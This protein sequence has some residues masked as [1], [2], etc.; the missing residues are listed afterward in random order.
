MKYVLYFRYATTILLLVIS[1]FHLLP[2]FTFGVVCWLL[3][4][5]HKIYKILSEES[6][7]TDLFGKLYTP[8]LI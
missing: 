6:L 8:Y 2:L 5:F 7:N 4:I 3:E 1:L